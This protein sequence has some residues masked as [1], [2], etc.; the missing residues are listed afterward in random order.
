MLSNSSITPPNK[1]LIKLLLNYLSVKVMVINLQ[2]LS[3]YSKLQD[4]FIMKKVEEYTNIIYWIYQDLVFLIQLLFYFI[5][6][7]KVVKFVRIDNC[8][9]V[10]KIIAIPIRK[11]QNFTKK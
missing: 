11:I 7:Y 4:L 5:F 8:L 9:V 1:L 6:R 10:L 3:A 2:N